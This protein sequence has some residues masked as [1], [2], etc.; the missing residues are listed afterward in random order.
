MGPI[1]SARVRPPNSARGLASLAAISPRASSQ[2]PRRPPR[3]PP[4]PDVY[5][6][7]A[8]QLAHMAGGL[9]YPGFCSHGCL[10]RIVAN[11]ISPPSLR[12]RGEPVGLFYSWVG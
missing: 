11:T 4:L 7:P 6:H 8:A 9:D 10:P 3:P 12:T 1:E 5:I 2:L